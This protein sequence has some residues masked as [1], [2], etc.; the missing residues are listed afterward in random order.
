MGNELN[1]R[2]TAAVLMSTPTRSTIGCAGRRSDWVGRYASAGIHP[3]A[4]ALRRERKPRETAETH[5]TDAGGIRR[6]S[7]VRAKAHRWRRGETEYC[8]W[9]LV[10]R[11]ISA[12][13]LQLRC[14]RSQ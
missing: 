14:D 12:A 9:P 10:D 13:I 1:R 8:D 6:T 11:P 3:V 5:S 7:N 4:A 2:R